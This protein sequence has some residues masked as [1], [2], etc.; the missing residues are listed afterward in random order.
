M[1]LNRDWTIDMYGFCM[2]QKHDDDGKKHKS[3]VQ[4]Y[5][6][7]HTHKNDSFSMSINTKKLIVI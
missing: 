4:Q 6:H 2:Q 7:L 3:H 5:I 1:K